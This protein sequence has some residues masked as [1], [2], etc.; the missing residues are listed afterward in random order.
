M[1]EP[2]SHTVVTELLRLSKE[3][4]W[5]LGPGERVPLCV[6][7]ALLPA[8]R[9]AKLTGPQR[10]QEGLPRLL[11][12]FSGEDCG[13]TPSS[14]P[15]VLPSVLPQTLPTKASGGTYISCHLT[16]VSPEQV[17]RV[18]VPPNVAFELGKKKRSLGIREGQASWDESHDS[19]IHSWWWQPR[20][21]LEFMGGDSDE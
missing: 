12:Q 18:P 10:S 14:C 13:E 15:W 11:S 5:L 21:M 6:S 4:V 1:P 7:P 8:C 9:H 20:E 3:G 17:L 16:P 19:V 2:H